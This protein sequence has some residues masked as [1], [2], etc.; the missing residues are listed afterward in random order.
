MI[1]LTKAVADAELEEVVASTRGCRNELTCSHQD[2][3]LRTTSKTWG[4]LLVATK[5]AHSERFM[6]LEL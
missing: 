2:A 6:V 3:I 4:W 5:L 1:A